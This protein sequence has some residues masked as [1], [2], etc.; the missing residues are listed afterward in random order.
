MARMQQG[1]FVRVDSKGVRTSTP[2]DEAPAT[3]KRKRKPLAIGEAN[4]A[5]KAAVE[6][7]GMKRGGMVKK[8]GKGRYC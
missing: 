5:N 7:A 4:K 1:N 2:M 3:A 6:A 8:A